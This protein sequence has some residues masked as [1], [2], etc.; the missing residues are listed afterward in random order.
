MFW[1]SQTPFDKLNELAAKEACTKKLPNWSQIAIER[2]RFHLRKRHFIS[3]RNGISFVIWVKPFYVRIVDTFQF[4]Y[5]SNIASFS[6]FIQFLN[7]LNPQLRT[8]P[9]FWQLLGGVILLTDPTNYRRESESVLATTEVGWY[10]YSP[11]SFGSIVVVK[12]MSGLRRHWPTK[13]LK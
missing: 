3:L 1:L 7:E 12:I 4:L 6:T 10:Q 2:K 5:R 9:K 8:Q 13:Q 11:R